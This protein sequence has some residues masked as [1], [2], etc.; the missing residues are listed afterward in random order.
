[1]NPRPCFLFADESQLF[2]TQFD[3]LF[4]TTARSSRCCTVYLSQNLNNYLA[5]YKGSSGQADAKSLLGNLTHH[6]VHALAD[7]DTANFIAELIG[8]SRQWFLSG[9]SGPSQFDPLDNCWAIRRKRFP[10]ATASNFPM[11]WTRRNCSAC[12]PAGPD[13]ATAWRDWSGAAAGRSPP[14]APPTCGLPSTNGADTMNRDRTEE[15]LSELRGTINL[16]HFFARQQHCRARSSSAASA[17]GATAT[18]DSPRSWEWS[19]RR[20]SPPCTAP[21]RACPG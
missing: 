21:T 2:T 5:A 13:P 19:G 18:W 3:A 16:L 15:P 8:R 4:Q 10:P 9:N 7:S 17:P 11:M 1:V 12:R 20:S 6:V 14:P